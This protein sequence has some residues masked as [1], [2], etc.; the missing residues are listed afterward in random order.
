MQTECAR[1]EELINDLLDLQRLEAGIR[2]SED[3]ELLDLRYWMFEIVESFQIRAQSRQQSLE[4]QIS[5]IPPVLLDTSRVR[6][7]ITELLN[8]ACKYTSPGGTISLEVC[9]NFDSSISTTDTTA[10]IT[11]IVK[12]QAQIPD[13][14]LP[15]LFDRFYRVP[16]S[17]RWHQGG[18]GLGLTL[19]QKIVEH[20]QGEIQVSSEAGCTQFIVHLPT[21]L[22]NF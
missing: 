2:E 15:H 8:N 9:S 1:E 10:V 4:I 7:I 12:N 22:A 14:A 5:D 17:D 11:F 20:L 13:T 21:Q 6:R 3:L 18:S 16:G 19:V